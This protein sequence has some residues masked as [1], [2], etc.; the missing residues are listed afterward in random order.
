M[1]QPNI[2]L[3]TIDSL[4]AD[5]VYE[6][7]AATPTLD[8]LADS[9]TVYERAFA[10]GPFTTF[11]MPS[12]FT[13]RYPSGLSYVTFSED[14][15]GVAIQEE[16]TLTSVLNDGGYQTA[17]FHSNPLLS[18][19]F[20]FDRG[21]GK[22][23]AGLPFSDTNLLPGRAKI[24]ADKLIRVLRTHPYL[25]AHKL[26]DRA[27]SWLKQTDSDCPFFCWLHYMDVHGPYQAKQGNRYLNKYRAERLWRKAVTRPD[28]IGTAEHR[29][30]QELY[31]E[32]VEYTD[33][34]LGNLLDELQTQDLLEET[35]VAVTADHGEQFYDHG[36]YSHPHQTYDELTHVPLIV[37]GG[38]VPVESV[39][40][41]VPIAGL[42]PSLINRAGLTPPDSFAIESLSA[43]HEQ[44]I[45]EANLFPEYVAAVRTDRWKYVHDDRAENA[46]FDLEADSGEQKNVI[47]EHEDVADEFS[48]RL[49][50]HLK[51]TNREAGEGTA[52][53]DVSVD[54]ATADRLEDLGYM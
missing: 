18:N 17:G 29:R 37:S 19:L 38:D 22:F 8:G 7:R 20:G 49:S 30:L 31:Q 25:P 47:D 46:L 28:K 10:Q 54:D 16:P 14:T 43:M 42:T 45:T 41:L 27:V 26:N 11:S 39:S 6:G 21:F 2:L 40:E 34:C 32:E 48:D 15:I 33:R 9:G 13:A 53:T 5:Y 23:E 3:V 1:T 4:R 35:I 52:V 44:V 36:E 51:D 50:T 12:L 24:L